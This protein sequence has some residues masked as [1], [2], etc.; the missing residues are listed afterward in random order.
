MFH[1]IEASRADVMV[2]DGIE[3]DHQALLHPDLCATHVP[4]PFTRLDKAYM[5]TPDPAL[6]SAVDAWLDTEIMSGG[7]QRALDAAQRQ[8]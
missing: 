6:V 1:E 5:L 8:P 3:V 7:W 2:T 4:A